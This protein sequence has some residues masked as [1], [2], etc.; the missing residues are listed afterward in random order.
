M[1]KVK[2]M[3]VAIVAVLLIIVFGICFFQVRNIENKKSS[4]M[5]NIDILTENNSQVNENSESTVNVSASYADGVLTF[6]ELEETAAYAVRGIV[7]EITERNE[8]AQ[9]AEISVQENYKSE[10]G[11]TIHLCQVL[12]DN[13][14]E[15]GKEY[16]LFMNRQ[17]ADDPAGESYYPVSGGTGVM[18][19]ESDGCRIVVDKEYLI[20]KDMDVWFNENTSF[21]LGEISDNVDRQ[22]TVMNR[23]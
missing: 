22:Y 13:T 7:T 1:N 9:I 18:L 23:E 20:N 5:N 2:N 14:V 16:I 15:I 21:V 10:T 6:S 3:K 8:L 4:Q 11:E 19:V 17:N 12:E